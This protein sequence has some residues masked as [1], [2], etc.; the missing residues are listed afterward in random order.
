LL[1]GLLLGLLPSELAKLQLRQ[2]RD[3]GQVSHHFVTFHPRWIKPRVHPK[4]AREELAA[5]LPV[6]ASSRV[7]PPA[8]RSLQ[9]RNW[10]QRLHEGIDLLV[11][12]LL[13]RRME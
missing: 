5:R 7:L 3:Q 2:A 11:N 8:H 13:L 1:L 6:L 12:A 10:L 4:H 9:R